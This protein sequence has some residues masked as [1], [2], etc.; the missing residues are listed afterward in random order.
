MGG[1]ELGV[2]AFAKAV[3]ELIEDDQETEL[4]LAIF[5]GS[6]LYQLN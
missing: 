6:E 2:T 4:V 3:K 1:Q 5:D